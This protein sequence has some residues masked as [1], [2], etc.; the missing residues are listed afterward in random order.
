MYG[1]FLY[2]LNYEEYKKNELEM[3][4]KIKMLS[5]EGEDE[6]IEALDETYIIRVDDEEFRIDD[7]EYYLMLVGSHRFDA[8][9]IEDVLYGNET[10]YA[11]YKEL[12]KKETKEMTSEELAEVVHLQSQFI[13]QEPDD[14]DIFEEMVYDGN[15]EYG[16]MLKQ[17]F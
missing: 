9:Y 4:K 14:V 8:D 12:K 6:E 3:D 2:R 16:E 11:R 5:E 1:A 15:T 17:V 13:A 7:N 10:D